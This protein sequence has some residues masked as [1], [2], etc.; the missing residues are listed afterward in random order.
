MLKI[1]HDVTLKDVETEEKRLVEAKEK[2]L[3]GSLAVL[4]IQSLLY[5]Y[6]LDIEVKID[7]FTWGAININPKCAN[8]HQRHQVIAYFTKKFGAFEKEV[9]INDG[10]VYWYCQFGFKY[11]G[12]EYSIYI[13]DAPIEKNCKLVE[14]ET[15]ETVTKTKWEMVCK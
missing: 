9:N 1:D 8:N 7:L 15:E 2:N 14:T 6:I 5:D 10:A 3:Q 4:E 13:Y 11:A 12:Y